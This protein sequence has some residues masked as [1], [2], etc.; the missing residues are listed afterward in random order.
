MTFMQRL[1]NFLFLT[2][3]NMSMKSDMGIRGYRH[4]LKKYVPEVNSFKEIV[5]QS[6][7]F[8]VTREH[9]AQWPLPTMPNVIMVPSVGCLPPKSLPDDLDKIVSSSKYGV[10][11]VSFGSAAEYLLVDVIVKFVAAFKEV[12]QDVIW[13]FPSKESSSANFFLSNN[14]HVVNWFPKNDLLGHVNTKLFITHCGNNG[15]YES[16]YQGVPMVTF[17]LFAEQHH[18][19]FRIKYKGFGVNLDIATFTSKELVNAINEVIDNMTFSDNLRT[20]SLLLKNAPMIPRD[21]IAYWIEHVIKFG[22]Y[23]LR[24]HATDLAWYHYFNVDVLAFILS[25]IVVITY[26]F[27]KLL[28]CCFRRLEKIHLK[29]KAN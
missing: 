17:P 6:Q 11:G 25:V 3:E 29:N 4:L 15:Q 24:S 1:I 26:I 23:H 14:V 12:K 20:A 16:I 2:G 18:N 9:V 22:H 19:A 21:T 7:L 8:F 13:K 28:S 5:D 27:F 10:I